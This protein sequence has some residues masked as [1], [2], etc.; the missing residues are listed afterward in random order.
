MRCHVCST[1]GSGGDG[2]SCILVLCTIRIM[3]GASAALSCTV[4]LFLALV[5]CYFCTYLHI[6]AH[7]LSAVPQ[8]GAGKCS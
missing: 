5:L 4:C 1:L 2:G 3:P 6:S 8:S 7:I